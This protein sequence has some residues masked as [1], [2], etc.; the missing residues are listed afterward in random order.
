[1]ADIVGIIGPGGEGGTFLDWS[2]NYLV[3][4]KILNV[5]TVDRIN[6]IIRGNYKCTILPN[7]ITKEGNAHNH[8]KTHP[9]EATLQDCVNLLK[10]LDSDNKIH[11]LYAVP[12]AITYTKFNSF[13]LFIKHTVST[14]TGL[15]FIQMYYPSDSTEDLVY[16]IYNKIPQCNETIDKIRSRVLAESNSTDKIVDD[17][18]VY[19]LNINNMFYNLDTEIHKIF[20]WLNLDIQEKRY[21]VWISVYKKWQLA[22]NFKGM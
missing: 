20:S 2:L 3:G 8:K 4:N 18:N 11:T 22:Q 12:V 1:M 9:T 10:T 14:V 21:N 16:R 13:S 7:P 17:P 15:K 6:N 19:S 5:I